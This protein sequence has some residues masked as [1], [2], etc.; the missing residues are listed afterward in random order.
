[1]GGTIEP[2]LGQGTAMATTDEQIRALQEK[3]EE[4]SNQVGILEDIHAIRRLQHAYGYY[5][6][7]CL[8]DETVDLFAGDGQVRFMG[9]IFKAK[10]GIRRLYI[11]RFRKNFTNGI[12]GPVHGFLLDHPQMQDVI[13]VAPDRR[14]AKARFRCSMQAGRHESFKPANGQTAVAPRQW[15]EGGLYEN[16]YVRD[17]GVWKIK[18]LN[19]RPVWHADYETGWAHTRPEYVA[20]FSKTYPNDPL[21]PDELEDPKPVLWPDTDVVAFHYPHP[22]TGRIIKA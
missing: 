18:V 16:E 10:P 17:A 14:T 21:G 2:R 19:Y 22:V 12:N 5:I 3:I 1:L 13:D 8:Y 4:L 9:G 20:F 11:E 7:K 15:W 6:D